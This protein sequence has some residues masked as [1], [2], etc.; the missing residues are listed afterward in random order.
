MLAKGLVNSKTGH[1][2]S[3]TVYEGIEFHLVKRHSW[4]TSTRTERQ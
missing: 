2:F 1:Q 3:V 4:Q